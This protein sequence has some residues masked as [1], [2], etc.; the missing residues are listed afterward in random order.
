MLWFP[1]SPRWLFDHGHEDKA[2]EILADLH[3]KG[4][5][6]DA[7]VQLEFEEIRQQVYFERTEG[8]KSYIDLL[9]PD[10]FRRVV[11]GTCLQMWRY[12]NPSRK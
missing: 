10:V 8:A 5:K 3:G 6:D 1:E 11:L 2:L 9:K 4:N 12:V 7:L